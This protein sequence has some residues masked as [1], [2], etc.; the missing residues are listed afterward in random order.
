MVMS[1]YKK[2]DEFMINHLNNVLIEG[3]LVTEPEIVAKSKD[4][5]KNQFTLAKTRLATDRFYVD[6]NGEKQVDT[7]FIDI[8]MWGNLAERAVSS[9]SKG[10]TCRIVGRLKMCSW[11]GE[12]GTKKRSIEIVANHI[13]FNR[14]KKKMDGSKAEEKV[15]LEDS[16]R[17]CDKLCEKEVIYA[18]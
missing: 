9:L 3:I 15:V 13:E 1:E 14:P 8:Q 16:E 6:R 17:E 10:M 12:G 4:G 11:D 5:D 7:L 2:E 18:Y